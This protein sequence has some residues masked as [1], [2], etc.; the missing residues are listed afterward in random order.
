MS[1]RKLV[2]ANGI[3]YVEI[4]AAGLYLMCGAPADSV[5]HLLRRGII[6][7]TEINGVTYENGPNAL[8]LS[9]VMV[10]NGMLS[11]LAEFPILQMLYRQGMMI[12]NHPNNT[13]LRPKLIG[14][15]EQ[16]AAQLRYIHRGNYGLISAEEMMKAGASEAYADELMRIKLKFAFGQISRPEVFVDCH[17]LAT[18]PIDLGNGVSI[19]RLAHN[20]F[21][22]RHEDAFVE[23]DLNLPAHTIYP[24]PYP[25]SHAPIDRHYFSVVH[26]GDG[27][28]WDFNRP[29]MGSVLIHQGRVYL[30]DAGPN[31]QYSLDALGIGKKEVAGIFHTHVHDDH[32]AG[33]TT[34]MQCDRA[35]QYFATPLVRASVVRKF[36]ALLALPESEFANYFDIHDLVEGEWN[37][38]MGLEAKPTM[39][40]HPVE[41]TVFNFRVL[42][43]GG[44]RTYAHMA[45]IASFKVLDA[46]ITADPTAP[47]LSR[48]RVAATKAAYLAPA[49][50]KKIDIGGGL[51][52]GEAA[53]FAKD[54]SPRL[55]LAHIPRDLT[56]DERRIGSGAPFGTVDVLIPGE[57]NFLLRDAS[58]LLRSYFPTV[59]VERLHMLL[60][61][62]IV[63]FNPET[64]M[65]SAGKVP[66]EIY[67]VL[68][69]KVEVL[70][71]DPSNTHF[72]FSG[73]VLAESA[74]IHATA[75]EETYR[76]VGFV[77]ALRLPSD[78]Y[79]SFVER[80]FSSDELLAIRKVEEKLRRTFLF[81]DAVTNTTLFMLAKNC[82]IARVAA[83]RKFKG[84]PQ[85]IHLIGRGRLARGKGEKAPVLGKGEFWGFDELFEAMTPAGAAVETLPESP[86]LALDSCEVYSVPLSLVA[87]IPVVRWKL[88]EAFRGTHPYATPR[89]RGTA[90]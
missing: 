81:S 15:P 20:V 71:G 30:I 16:I 87:R 10:Q 44:Y 38:I 23:V 52:H 11:N 25:L 35:L 53:D 56:P 31:I 19:K 43:E 83:G 51:I 61:N 88:F 46:M 21:D 3:C 62:R 63:T 18:E 4:P 41:T 1:I 82:H 90:R 50:I 78:L 59:P 86:L 24:C 70:T 8:L 54:P 7:T 79:R 32:F 13:G 75:S 49:D 42:W 48:E 89:Y 12:P 40:P 80:F 45:D 36:S 6:Q 84:L 55:L 5:K 47:G 85:H 73:S 58:E 34:L 22:I 57:Q 14:T 60:N 66:H 2:V 67:L 29:A 39:S 17:V 65:I 27:D 68:A 9:D 64:I 26:A 72:L 33:L 37:D 28:G 69:G 76:T 74:A 77:Q